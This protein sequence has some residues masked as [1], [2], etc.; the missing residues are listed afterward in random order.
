MNHTMRDA[1]PDESAL[2]S[3]LALRSKG[4][5]PYSAEFLEACREELTYP[6]DKISCPDYRFVVI[7]RADADGLAGFVLLHLA[8]AEQVDMDALFVEPACI[9]QGVGKA[10]WLR[11]VELAREY[12]A[13][14]I[15]IHADPYAEPFY[16]AM[17]ARRVGDVPSGSVPGR[18]LPRMHFDL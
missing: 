1:R 10:L 14:R 17:G 12:G 9:G 11:G 13:K 7:E 18:V 5:W 3:D 15:E 4:Y 8:S 6:P 2:I 16:S